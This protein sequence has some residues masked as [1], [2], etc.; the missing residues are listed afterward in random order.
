MFWFRFKLYWRTLVATWQTFGLSKPLYVYGLRRPL[1]MGFNQATLA[2]DNVFFPGYRRVEVRRPLFIIGHPRSGTTFLHRLLAGTREYCTF[3]AWEIFIPA[4]LARK[5]LRPIIERRIRSGQAVFFPKEVG[6]EGALDQVEEEE[7]LFLCNGN[8]Q[9]VSCLSP[10]AF[11]DW[12][13]TELVYADDQPEPLRRATMKFLKGC[14]QRQIYATGRTQ[15]VAKMNYSGMRLRALLAAFPD[16]RIVYVARSPLETIPSHLTL[17]R[18]MFEHQWGLTRIPK[19]RLDRY[20]ERRYRHNVGFYRYVENLL[21]SGDLPRDQ[22]LVLPYEQLRHDLVAS[23]NRVAEFSGIT[24][25]PTLRARIEAQ[26]QQQKNYER[27][28]K[29]LD[30]EEFGLTREQVVKDLEFVFDKYGFEK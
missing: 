28:H 10:L 21:D 29:N 4:L 22:V 14:F 15:V 26:G 13:F 5:L 1:A 16:A 6:H 20:Y 7:V 27:R 12:D 18:N 9:F 3:D 25:S 8:T 30:L 24:I 17:H 2:L 23:M 19:D 11:S